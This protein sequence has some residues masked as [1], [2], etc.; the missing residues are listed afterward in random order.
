MHGKLV[1]DIDAEYTEFLETYKQAKNN[2]RPCKQPLEKEEVLKLA[3]A[4]EL[5]AITWSKFC[6]WLP[7]DFVPGVGAAAPQAPKAPPKKR[8]KGPEWHVPELAER[9]RAP[10][11]PDNAPAEMCEDSSSSSSSSSSDSSWESGAPFAAEE[12]DMP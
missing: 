5:G 8:K 11:I 6:H 3:W 1:S 2:T 9:R 4:G 7:L 10:E 12:E